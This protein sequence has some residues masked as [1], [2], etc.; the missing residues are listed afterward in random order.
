[1][2]DKTN[3]SPEYAKA[4]GVLQEV[5]PEGTDPTKIWSALQD[6]GLTISAATISETEPA[7]DAGATGPDNVIKRLRV[8]L[9]PVVRFEHD[10]HP[11]P[12]GHRVIADALAPVMAQ[13][14]GDGNIRFLGRKDHQV[15]IRGYRVETGE[16]ENPDRVFYGVGWL[17]YT[18]MCPL[19]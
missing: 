4:L 7:P 14:L 5:L 1:M 12:Q 17:K 9:D 13:W 3:D 18:R 15:K 8:G 2:A 6:A 16:I 11:T 19:L 10:I